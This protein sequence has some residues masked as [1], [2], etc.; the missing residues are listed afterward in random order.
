MEKFNNY[1]ILA[2]SDTSNG[3]ETYLIIGLSIGLVVIGIAIFFMI[4]KYLS[5]K[6]KKK[7]IEMQRLRS[8]FKRSYAENYKKG[9][10][11]FS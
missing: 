10:S 1:R 8:I 7:Y 5:T 3:N 11:K 4:S 9:S 2:S 6:R